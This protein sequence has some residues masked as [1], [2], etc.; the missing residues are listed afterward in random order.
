MSRRKPTRKEKMFT[1]MMTL[2][3]LGGSAATVGAMQATPTANLDQI[4]LGNISENV[5]EEAAETGNESLVTNA[6]IEAPTGFFAIFAEEDDDEDFNDFEDLMALFDN[7]N[8]RRG[9]R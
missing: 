7:G 9:R 1:A 3:I 4:V 8:R 6:T 2:F 5:V